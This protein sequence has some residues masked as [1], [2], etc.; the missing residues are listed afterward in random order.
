MVFRWHI[1]GESG[2]IHHFEIDLPNE[3]FLGK[4]YN[5]T[6]RAVDSEGNVVP[7]YQGTIELASTDESASLPGD[8]EKSRGRMFLL[9]K[10]GSC[11]CIACHEIR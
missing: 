8:S 1:P 11:H 9:P 5:L 10:N 7:D 4:D 3:V 6:I 2:V